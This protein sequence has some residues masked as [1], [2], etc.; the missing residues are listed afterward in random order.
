MSA[1][2][3]N[4]PMEPFTD[5]KWTDEPEG[6]LKMTSGNDKC[7]GDFPLDRAQL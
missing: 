4:D 7:Q 1:S 2:F 3:H 5:A 6:K